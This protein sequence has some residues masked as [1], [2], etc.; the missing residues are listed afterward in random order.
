[1]IPLEVAHQNDFIKIEAN[2][3][4]N[5]LKI[6]WLQHPH[7]ENFRQET[8]RFAEFALQRNLTNVLL[9][10]RERVYLAI[11]DQNWLIDEIL[12]LIKNRTV[13]FAYLINIED[14]DIMDTYKVHDLIL[15]NPQYNKQVSGMIFLNEE[16]AQNWLLEIGLYL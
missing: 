12:P 5:Y 7:S 14:F 13:R 11:K 6:T 2:S 15:T 3:E 10:V 16:E 9:D 1:M 8:K 4:Y